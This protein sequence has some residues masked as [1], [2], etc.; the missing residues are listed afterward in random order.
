MDQD[1]GVTVNRVL[2]D[3]G[4]GRNSV[5]GQIGLKTNV[6]TY[7]WSGVPVSDRAR[8]VDAVPSRGPKVDGPR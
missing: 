5:A 8:P 7:A 2:Q 1:I 4:Q 3:V 6:P